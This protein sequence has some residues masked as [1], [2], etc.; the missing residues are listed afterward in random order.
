MYFKTRN[1]LIKNPNI[2]YY[3][4]LVWEKKINK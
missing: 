2:K 4:A 1:Q 3:L